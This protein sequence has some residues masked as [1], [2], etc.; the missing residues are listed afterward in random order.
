MRR[1]LPILACC[2]FLTPPT[3]GEERVNPEGIPYKYL[4]GVITFRHGDQ[5]VVSL[6]G[7]LFPRKVKVI[8]DTPE[9][10][11]VTPFLLPSAFGGP[12][13]PPLPEGIPALLRVE[14]PDTYGILYIDGELVRSRDTVR[15]LQSPP[16]APGKSY[17][18]HIRAAFKVGDNLL[19]EDRQVFLR[20][21]EATAV[22]FDGSRALTVPLPRDDTESVQVP[23]SR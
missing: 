18:L 20:A 9:G 14:I 22:T 21:G 17:P 10:R 23:R 7:V 12:A 4:G 6:G 5:T 13:A 11:I 15:Q 19:I 8:T 3:R 16:L 2:F 1:A